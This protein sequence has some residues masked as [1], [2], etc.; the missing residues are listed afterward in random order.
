MGCI[1]T[2]VYRMALPAG[3]VGLSRAGAADRGGRARLPECGE[4]LGRW[5][6]YW[7]WVR[8]PA[9]ARLWIRRGRCRNAGARMRCCRIF[10]WSVDWTRSR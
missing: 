10:C 2:L 5:G 3:R 7:R 6:G 9:T 8:G 1:T 4:R